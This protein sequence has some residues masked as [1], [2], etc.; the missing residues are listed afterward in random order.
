MVQITRQTYSGKARNLF[1]TMIVTAYIYSMHKTILSVIILTVILSFPVSALEI[2]FS[3]PSFINI[4]EDFDV[5]ISTTDTETYDVKIFLKQ[6]T[7]TLSSEIQTP[8]GWKNAYYYL[9]SSLPTQHVY[10][11]RLKQ[12]LSQDSDASLCVRL[13]KPNQTSYEENCKDITI[14]SSENPEVQ[15]DTESPEETKNKNDDVESLESPV[16]SNPGTSSQSEEVEEN[17][18]IIL[19][20]SFKSPAETLS[21]QAKIRIGINYALAIVVLIALFIVAKRHNREF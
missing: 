17:E 8:E 6:S 2:S 20:N 7:D 18:P 3:S 5:D 12:S 19:R 13:R 21:R 4:M 1:G 9:K 15:T 16:N 11:L 10:T 14:V